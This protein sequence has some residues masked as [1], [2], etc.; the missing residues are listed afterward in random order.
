MFS[1]NDTGPLVIENC[2]PNANTIRKHNFQNLVSFNA[3]FEHVFID[4]S[5]PF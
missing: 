5:E 4:A 3:L 1:E 2:T